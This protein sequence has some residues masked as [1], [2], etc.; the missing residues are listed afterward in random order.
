MQPSGLGAG[1]YIITNNLIEDC[2]PPCQDT[3]ASPGPLIQLAHNASGVISGNA[4]CKVNI[5]DMMV[6]ADFVDHSF[7]CCF[8]CS[9][10]ISA[11]RSATYFELK[12]CPSSS[13]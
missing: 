8:R 13:P 12:P 7:M 4:F 6:A 10:D 11:K 1:S 5:S 2:M 3:D 9:R